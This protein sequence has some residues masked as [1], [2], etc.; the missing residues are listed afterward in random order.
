MVKNIFL[1]K[2]TYF[3]FITLILIVIFSNSSCIKYSF[4]G[5]SVPVEAKSVSVKT[6]PN[7][8]SLVNPTLS[9]QFTEEL[10]TKIQSQ[11]NL[12]LN[13]SSADLTFEGE[14]THYYTQPIAIQGN[15]TAALNRLT[16]TINVRYSNRFNEKQNFEQSFSRYLDYDS[17]KNLSEVEGELI[18]QIS[19]LLVEDIFNKA[20]VNW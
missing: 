19:A 3:K 15:Q 10:R 9:S 16:I 17:S 18:R 11:S 1:L 8:A 2:R 14:I 7:N 13:E 5:A 20:F 6:F 12:M 4:S